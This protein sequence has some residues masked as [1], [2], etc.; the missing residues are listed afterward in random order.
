VIQRIYNVPK[1]SSWNP[2]AFIDQIDI[3][4]RDDA[5][6]LLYIPYTSELTENQID[7]LPGQELLGPTYNANQFQLTCHASET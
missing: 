5:G 2:G 6:N 3:Q 4:L 7:P 1:Y